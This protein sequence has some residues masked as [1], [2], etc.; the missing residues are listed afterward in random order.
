MTHLAR[1]GA[2][3][4]AI[5]PSPKALTTPLAGNRQP[6]TQRLADCRA[7]IAALETAWVTAAEQ[8]LAHTLPRSIRIDDRS[9]WDRTTWDRY[10]AEAAAA[11]P[12][13]KPRLRRLYQQVQ[14][15]ER[16]LAAPAPPKAHPT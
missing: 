5:S 2:L 1:P 15:L 11:E 16:L 14:N 7:E 8:A 9:T 3:A 4:P 10:H 13:F 12:E 6:L